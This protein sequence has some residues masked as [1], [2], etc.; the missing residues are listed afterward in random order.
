[1]L[2]E[3]QA[4]GFEPVAKALNNTMKNC[5]PIFAAAGLA[6]SSLSTFA[7][8]L[9]T[10][11]PLNGGDQKLFV[12][13][14]SLP[15]TLSVAAF[16]YN[17]SQNNSPLYGLT[18]T[19]G[20]K[21]LNLTLA[22]DTSNDVCYFTGVPGWL[23]VSFT[24]E[25][26]LL[27]D[28]ILENGGTVK[29]KTKAS[30]TGISYPATYTVTVRKVASVTVPGG[31]FSNCRSITCSEVAD[32]RGQTVSATALTAY[33]A[34]GVGIIKTLLSGG[35]WAEL[36]SGTVGGVPV[37]NGDMSEITVGV[38]GK[39]SVAPNYSG[40][41]LEINHAYTMTASPKSGYTFDNWTGANGVVCTT[42]KYSFPMQTN[43]A[44]QA[45][46]VPDPFLAPAGGYTGLFSPASGP[47]VQNSGYCQLAV[48][49]KGAF[50][51]Y[52]Q[53]GATRHPISGQ[54]D[55]DGTWAKTINVSGRNPWS[56]TLNV[57]LS[58]GNAIGGVISNG[59][60]TAQLTANKSVFNATKDRAT[61][62]GDYTMIFDGANGP[63]T[64]PEGDGYA[65][66]AI[67]ENGAVTLSGSL[68]DGSKITPSATLSQYGKWPFYASLYGGA[69]CVS[70]WVGV[71][72]SGAV[73]GSVVWIKPGGTGGNYPGGFTFPT[74]ASGGLY[75]KSA[76]INGLNFTNAV[77]SGGALAGAFTNEISIGSNHKVLN[78]SSSKLTMTFSPSTGI[79]QGAVVNPAAPGSKAMPFGG[80]LLQN[81]ST[82]LGY[83]LD[84]SQS[85][86]FT[87]KS[88]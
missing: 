54:F 52:L 47:T 80:V 87:L 34:P 18:E 50:S 7:G 67:G 65:Y 26:V 29:T 71:G 37:G 55:G 40:H 19:Y 42:E 48:T 46:F 64:L 12:Y 53:T 72:D 16:G 41:L 86:T 78:L 59:T 20:S 73:S 31:T 61:F 22:D 6:L 66:V 17:D 9:E 11:F 23:H 38:A 63:T 85:G 45:N 13:D 5:L 33:L 58:G 44:L 10:Y 1:M 32:V 76:G 74:T 36:V 27:N 4:K 25:V 75:S 24:P 88:Q 77:F 39:G 35:H 81:Q 83:F 15:L 57:D 70:G 56:V 2:P 51:G 84:A 62:A 79:F 60:W 3:S 8:A 28:A 21:T 14:S 82:A 69:G 68:A 49:T 30:Q 43:L